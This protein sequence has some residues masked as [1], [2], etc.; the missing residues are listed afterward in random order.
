MATLRRQHFRILQRCIGLALTVGLFAC[1]AT[2]P[3]VANPPSPAEPPTA[4]PNAVPPAT[5]PPESTAPASP[6]PAATS[7]ATPAVESTAQAPRLEVYWLQDKDNKLE[8]AAAKVTLADDVGESPTEQ[9]TAAMERL[10]T[11]SANADV[12]SAIP[13]ATQLNKLTVEADGVHIDLNKE[14]TTGG[15]SASMQGRLGQVVYTAS[16]LNPQEKVWL[17]VEGEPLEVMG[18]E[19]LEVSQP[20]TRQEF[21]QAFSL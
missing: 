8:L 3:E 11:G 6:S 12:T 13:E 7:T 14:F 18:G 17:S 10:L 1:E 9:L 21:D 5:P 15:G 19:G 20:M 4:A 2:P 16:S